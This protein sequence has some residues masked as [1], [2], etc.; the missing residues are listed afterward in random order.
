M[1]PVARKNL[2]YGNLQVRLSALE[3][4]RQRLTE[5]GLLDQD[6]TESFQ[7]SRE[8]DDKT[9][10]ILSVYIEDVEK[11]LAVFDELADKI[12]L[13]TRII[14]KRFSYKQVTIDKDQGFVFTNS[15]SVTL[16]PTDLSSGEQHE[17]VLLYELLFKVKPHS[18]I[19]IDEPELSLHVAWQMDF[20]SDLQEVT[21]LSVMDILIATHSPQIINDRW[22]LTVRLKGPGNERI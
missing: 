10:F 3:E 6:S 1:N 5:A 13:L 20:L 2:T 4:K 17:L 16:S 14:N 22:D 11:K 8:T 19:L 21:K 7:V 18:L 9:N 12:G 15:K